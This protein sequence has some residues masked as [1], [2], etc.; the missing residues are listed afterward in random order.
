MLYDGPTITDDKILIWDVVPSPERIAQVSGDLTADG[1]DV[2]IYNDGGDPGWLENEDVA[3]I[4]GLLA[5]R[6]MRMR[7]VVLDGVPPLYHIVPRAP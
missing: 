2:Y 6:G 4:R 3:T 1:R 5:E 7:T